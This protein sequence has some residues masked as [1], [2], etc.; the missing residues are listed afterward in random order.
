LRERWRGIQKIPLFKQKG[1][2]FPR[3]KDHAWPLCYI[4]G[5][6]TKDLEKLTSAWEEIAS[7]SQTRHVP[8]MVLLLDSG[9]LTSKMRECIS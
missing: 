1:Q 6:E 4:V 5:A 3:M 7:D 9:Y 2:S 8:Q